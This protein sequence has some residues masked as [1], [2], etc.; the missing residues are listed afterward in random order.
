MIES[1]K[2]SVTIV[3][4]LCKIK[5]SGDVKVEASGHIALAGT[6]GI[7]FM[8][9][10]SIIVSGKEIKCDGEVKIKASVIVMN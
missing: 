6:G 8:N 5:A 7:V 3:S 2:S 9:S 4:A 1:E 10:S